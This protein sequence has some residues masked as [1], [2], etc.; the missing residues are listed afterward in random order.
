[1]Y[2]LLS[3]RKVLAGVGAIA[4]LGVRHSIAQQTPEFILT[5]GKIST[6]DPARPEASAL[7]IRGGLI[8]STGTDSEMLARKSQDAQVIDLG[9]RRVIPGLND[10]HMHPIR[11]GRF[12][13]AELRWDGVSNLERGLEMIAEQAKRTP[14]GQWVRVIGGWSPH[15]FAEKRLPTPEEL[16]KASP[17]RP[18]FVLFLYSRGFLNKAGAEALKITSAAKPPPGGRYE[19]TP[20]GGAILWAEPSSAILNMAMAKLPELTEAQQVNSTR[21]FYRELNRFGLTSIIDAGGGGHAFPKNYVGSERLAEAGEM[22]IRVSYY[23]FPQKPKEELAELR[24]FVQY[25]VNLNRAHR[26]EHGFVLEGAGEGITF[27]AIDFENFSAPLP[28]YQEPELA[29]GVD[30]GH[31]PASKTALAVAHSCDLWRVDQQHP[32]CF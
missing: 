1:M 2:P 12:Y 21:Q 9:G 5:N 32:R 20:D 17:D 24:T 6:L 3:R 14:E 30:G 25:A 16:T 19:M 31:A 7:I 11:A 28:D 13:N 26:L 22:P 29:R 4:A 15:Q 18:V 23:L 27:S 10:S 8:S